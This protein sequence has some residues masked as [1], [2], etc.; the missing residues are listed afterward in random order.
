MCSRVTNALIENAH[1]GAQFIFIEILLPHMIRV[2]AKDLKKLQSQN[3]MQELEKTNQ[4]RRQ[5]KGR[6]FQ[7][8]IK[9]RMHAN[10]AY[11]ELLFFVHQLS[12]N[13]KCNVK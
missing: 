5:S 7:Q 1:A 4:G 6:K 2:G 11:H 3:H 8:H 12:C 13:R 10:E 9:I